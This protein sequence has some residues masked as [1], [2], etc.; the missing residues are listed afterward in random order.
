MKKA[1][2]NLIPKKSNWQG[3]KN[4]NKHYYHK[5]I[6]YNFIVCKLLFLKFVFIVRHNTLIV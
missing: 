2:N 1:I 4:N 6:I 5:K 3:G